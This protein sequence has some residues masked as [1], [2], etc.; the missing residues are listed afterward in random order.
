MN[1]RNLKVYWDKR[2]WWWGYYRGPTHNYVI[3]PPIFCLV[4]RWDRKSKFRGM[5]LNPRLNSL[6]SEMYDKRLINLLTP[7]RK[8]SRDYITFPIRNRRT[9]PVEGESDAD[10]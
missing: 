10:G 5:P 2:D 6:L 9:D 7:H 4:F 3:I 8:L 1:L